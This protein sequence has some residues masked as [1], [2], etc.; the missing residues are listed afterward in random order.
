MRADRLLAL[1][2]QLQA[3]GR[4]TGKDLAEKLEVSERTVHRDMEALSTAG[5]PVFAVRGAGGGWQLD[6]EWK[7]QVP[8]LDEAELYALLM[9]QPRNVGDPGIAASATKAFNKLLAAMPSGLRNRAATIQ[10]RLYVDPAGWWGSPEDMRFLPV[11]QNA[12]IQ[13]R[14]LTIHYQRYDG[15]DSVRVADPLGLVAK[16]MSWYLVANTTKGFRTFRLS[17]I[18]D[19]QVLDLPCIRPADFDLENHWKQATASFRESR[20]RFRVTFTTDKETAKYIHQYCKPVREEVL[21]QSWK[22][23]I[24]MELTFSDEQEATF[25]LLGLGSKVEI[26]HPENFRKQIDDEVLKMHSQRKKNLRK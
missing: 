22:S 8:G 6:P 19:V 18:R 2:L 26:L 11:L 15:E 21:D 20:S 7:V 5:V 16:G 10:K 4:M 14:K 9:T 23:V 13:D 3:H 25:I 17:R 12:L 24:R 1:V